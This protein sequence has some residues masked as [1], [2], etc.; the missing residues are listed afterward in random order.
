MGR[1]NKMTVE[2]RIRKQVDRLVAKTKKGILERG[3]H[4]GPLVEFTEKSFELFRRT[5]DPLAYMDYL[6]EKVVE[7]TDYAMI[8]RGVRNFTDSLTPIFLA[9]AIAKKPKYLRGYVVLFEP[10]EIVTA[11][12]SIEHLRA[13]ETEQMVNGS[14]KPKIE[15]VKSRIW[16]GSLDLIVNE[17]EQKQKDHSIVLA[18]GAVYIPPS[19]K[20]VVAAMQF[21]ITYYNAQKWDSS[22]QDS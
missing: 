10:K 20:L 5:Q 1:K 7:I 21:G 8:Y 15:D 3:N 13:V 16:D 2:R 12:A 4:L 19:T 18:G 22:N 11:T 14:V 17:I 6:R 9:T